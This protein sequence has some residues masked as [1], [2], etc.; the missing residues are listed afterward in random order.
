M[1]SVV[2]A[3]FC[4]ALASASL[5]LLNESKL[6]IL[7]FLASNLVMFYFNTKSLQKGST[8]QVFSIGYVFNIVFTCMFGYLLFNEDVITANKV[9]GV[10]LITTGSIILRK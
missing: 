10:A 8:V 2:I 1:L 4:G 5:K 9:A 7:L 3:S 6:Y